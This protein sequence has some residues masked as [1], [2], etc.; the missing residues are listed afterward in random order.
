MMD[1]SLPGRRQSAWLATVFSPHPSPLTSGER[2]S[3]PLS[4]P[5]RGA[6]GEGGISSRPNRLSPYGVWWVILLTLPALWPLLRSGFFVSDDGRFHVYRIAALAEAWRQGVLYPRLFPEFGFGY[7]Q[8]VLNFY[9]PLSYYPAALLACVGFGPAAAMQLALAFGF[10][11]AALAAYGYARSLWGPAGGVLAAVVYTYFPYHLA[12]AYLRGALPEHF[13]FVWPPLILWAY[14]NAFRGEKP[15]RPL[16]WGALAWAALICTHNLTALLMAPVTLF[17]LLL[18]AWW[19]GRWRRLPEAFGSLA[20]GLGLSAAF[21]L[22]SLAESRYVGIGLGPSDGYQRHLAPPA[23]L[24]DF[25]PLYRYPPTGALY[26]PLSWLSVL[27]FWVV[28]GLSVW[29]LARRQTASAM[30]PLGFGLLL[31]ALSVFMTTTLALPVWKPLTPVLGHLQYP[32]RFLTLA[33][34]G[35]LVSAGALPSSLPQKGGRALTGIAALALLLVPL[36]TIPVQRLDISDAEVWAPDRMW[37]EDA[38]AGQIGATWTGEF[39][40]LTVTEQRWAVGRPRVGATDGLAPPSRPTVRLTQ[41][42]YAHLHLEVESATPMSVRLHQFFLP[43][44]VA[45]VDGR[46]AR[47]YPT[48]ELGLV[49]VDVPA[50]SHRVEVRFG[51]TPARAAGVASSAFAAALWAILAW[52]GRRLGKGLTG[53]AVALLALMIAF[54][55]N[56]LG[57]GQRTRQ[58]MPVEAALEDVALLIGYETAPARGQQALDVTLYWFALREVATNYKAFVHLVGEDGQIIAQHDGDP[59][60]GFTPTTRWRPG[61]IVPDRHRLPLP[62]GAKGVY[63]L[64]A[65]LYRLEPSL[66]NLTVAPPSPDG[67]VDLGPVMIR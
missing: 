44:W 7:G 2:E 37:R 66:R 11:L 53:A 4:I 32:W 52:Q 57:V 27:L 18:M 59:V 29:R 15:L 34:V 41:I 3:T 47:T 30:P 33:A 17:Y 67:R 39:L 35:L 23:A 61:E 26:H 64:K 43:G 10:L 46:P 28:V 45:A 22:P 6:G 54:G 56:G 1:V 60:G 13:A 5:G 16:L 14:A 25:S 51:P 38:E 50:G 65:G 62:D 48:G 40:P 24:V 19:T 36:P 21:W 49:T 42:G 8:A 55:L 63:R 31:A 58:P 12:D 20:L 9:A